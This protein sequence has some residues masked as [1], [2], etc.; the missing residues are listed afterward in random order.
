MEELRAPLDE[1]KA[2]QEE[3]QP[4][5]YEEDPYHVGRVDD[6]D[7]TLG[8]GE[9]EKDAEE[10]GYVDLEEAEEGAYADLAEGELESYA[11]LA[12]G[13]P[14]THADIAEGKR[15]EDADQRD[16]SFEETLPQA[17]AVYQHANATSRPAHL[18]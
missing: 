16:G 9:M 17:S 7:E 14:E 11:D 15:E 18:L 10:E 1:L 13:E 8:E 5:D 12:E 6:D 2:A 3:D 4:S